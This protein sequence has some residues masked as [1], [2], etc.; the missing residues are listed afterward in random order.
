MAKGVTLLGKI[1]TLFVLMA[2]G[3]MMTT[4]IFLA[5]T[6]TGNTHRFDVTIR[7]FY[8]PIKYDLA[9]SSFLETTDPQTGLPMKRI[10]TAAA[11]QRNGIVS[12]PPYQI[13]VK[14]VADPILS[15]IL[16]RPYLLKLANPELK[17]AGSEVG[18]T[19][20]LQKVSTNLFGLDGSS[21][22]LELYVG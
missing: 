20:K 10:L 4:F 1:F 6:Y 7:I 12:I 15:D 8:L 21:A 13:D 17:L 22:D 11:I 9:L 5:T 3:I 16:K 18:L 2:V 19:G 14:D